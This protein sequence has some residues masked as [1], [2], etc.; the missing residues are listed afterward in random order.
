M[1]K[2]LRI[3][4]PGPGALDR[5]YADKWPTHRAKRRRRNSKGKKK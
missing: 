4:E 2:P 5:R 3:P 1:M